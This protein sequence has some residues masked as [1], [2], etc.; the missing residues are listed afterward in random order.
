[1]TEKRIQ[2]TMRIPENLVEL[3]QESSK[4]QERTFGATIV[5]ILRDHYKTINTIEKLRKNHDNRYL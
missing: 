3:I 1:M 5:K 2:K 4:I